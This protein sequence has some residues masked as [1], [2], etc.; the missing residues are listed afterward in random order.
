MVTATAVDSLSNQ[1]SVRWSPTPYA[2]GYLVYVNYGMGGAFIANVTGGGTSTNVGAK[3]RALNTLQ[4]QAYN[5][6]AFSALSPGVQVYTYCCKCGVKGGGLERGE[7]GSGREGSCKR[8]RKWKGGGGVE[9][10]E[11]ERGGREGSGEM[12]GREGE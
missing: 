1:I 4:V 9:R 6:S 12:G 3:C 11:G 2:S 5:S 7:G 10:W 8:G